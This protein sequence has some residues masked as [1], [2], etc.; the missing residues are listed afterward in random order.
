MWTAAQVGLVLTTEQV[1]V[2]MNSMWHS[3]HCSRLQNFVPNC[4]TEITLQLETL[5]GSLGLP[6]ACIMYTE[7]A[8][9]AYPYVK[10]ARETKYY[11][12]IIW[13]LF[14]YFLNW[15]TLYFKIQRR[16]KHY[17]FNIH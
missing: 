14:M 16:R 6:Q 5:T 4:G 9:P 7:N 1:T 3:V 10:K 15:T 12:E 8:P 2:T 17:M 13:H 11:K